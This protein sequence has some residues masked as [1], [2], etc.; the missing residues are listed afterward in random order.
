MVFALGLRWVV[1]VW[2]SVVSWFHWLG[3]FDW[4]GSGS[5]MSRL[6]DLPGLIKVIILKSYVSRGNCSHALRSGY[7]AKAIINYRFFRSFLTKLQ[8]QTAKRIRAL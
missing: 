1:L 3:S 6:V 4:V 7:N 5:H 2:C 8:T